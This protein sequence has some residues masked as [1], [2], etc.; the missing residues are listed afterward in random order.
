[1][2]GTHP[3]NLVSI[4]LIGTYR[5]KVIYR[6]VSS[7]FSVPRSNFRTEK[8]FLHFFSDFCVLNEYLYHFQSLIIIKSVSNK[9]SS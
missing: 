2:V 9:F 5:S 6:R 3:E 8:Y 1:M 4:E 7:Q